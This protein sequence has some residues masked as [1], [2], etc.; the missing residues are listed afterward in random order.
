M[1]RRI[2]GAFVALIALVVLVAVVGAAFGSS[3]PSSSSPASVVNHA[4]QT[5][6]GL[7]R[8][9]RAAHKQL[10]HDAEYQS[11]QRMSHGQAPRNQR[12]CMYAYMRDVNA[13]KVAVGKVDP[14]LPS[15]CA[16]GGFYR[17]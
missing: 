12:D 6:V 11:E 16:R 15:L 9:H 5:K 2:F 7:D 13:G 4:V 17:H 8:Y 1:I 3:K 10:A 14:E